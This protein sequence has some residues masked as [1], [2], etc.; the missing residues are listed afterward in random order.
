M[1]K[2]RRFI[3]MAFSIGIFLV[4]VTVV[5]RDALAD[6]VSADPNVSESGYTTFEALSPPELWEVLDGIAFWSVPREAPDGHYDAV[7]ATSSEALRATLHELV[8]GHRVFPYTDPTRPSDG[9]HRVDTWDILAIADAHPERPREVLDIYLNGTFARQLA[10]IVSNPR[11]ERE[12]AWPKTLGFFKDT[13]DNAAYSDCHHLFAAYRSYNGS[14]GNKPYGMRPEDP[15]RRRMTL[16][17]LDRGGAFEDAPGGSNYSFSEVWQT[18]RG[19]RG[20]VSRAML[21][22]ALRYDGGPN[23][24]E[25]RLSD[26]IIDVVTRKEAWKTG[27]D[28][29]MGVRSTLLQWHLEDPVDD[30]E[31]RRN[32]VVFLFQGN[33]NPFVDHPEWVGPIFSGGG[34]VPQPDPVARVWISEIHYD[35]V[36]ADQGEFVELTGEAGVDLSGWKLVAYNGNGGVEY[37]E[38]ELDGVISDEGDGTGAIAFAAPGLQNGPQDGL[39][40]VAAT[41]VVVEVVSYEGSFGATDGDAAGLPSFD[42]GVAET[43]ATPIGFSLQRIEDASTASGFRWIGPRAGT[44]GTVNLDTEFP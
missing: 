43:G 14:R 34:V 27:A 21:Y 30:L 32:T 23:E 33:R 7:D 20:D 40:L 4:A 39:A 16:E 44:P 6:G 17:N 25:L 12:H 9:N 41:G 42:I 1:D 18:W 37:D 38:I 36:S 2:S 13:T 24:A 29:F 10:G 8:S 15:A 35:N 19:R 11:Y 26:D 31:R 22:M 5:A 3:A 28:A